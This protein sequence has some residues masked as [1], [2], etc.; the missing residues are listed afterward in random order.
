[1]KNRTGT[2]QRWAIVLLGA[3]LILSWIY[4]EVYASQVDHLLRGSPSTTAAIVLYLEP[5]FEGEVLL[6]PDPSWRLRGRQTFLLR[7]DGRSMRVPSRDNDDPSMYVTWSIKAVYDLDGTLRYIGEQ[8][9]T[10]TLAFAGTELR[11]Q[12]GMPVREFMVIRRVAAPD[13]YGK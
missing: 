6:E 10:G 11:S 7:Q 2:T 9:P 8:A 3:S 1:M 12:G 5:D 13:G 4:F